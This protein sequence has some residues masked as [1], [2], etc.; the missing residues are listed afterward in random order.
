MGATLS[1]LEYG[2]N[3]SGMGSGLGDIPESCM[4]CVFLFLTL[5]E[6]CNLARLNRVFRGAA[7]SDSVWERKLLPNYQ[8]LLDLLPPERKCS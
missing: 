7:S 6:I 2:T 8:D 5:P 1:C 3:G 4:A